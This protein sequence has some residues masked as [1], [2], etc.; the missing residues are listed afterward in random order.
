M[1]KKRE[2]LKN[3]IRRTVLDHFYLNLSIITNSFPELSYI[4][5][6]EDSTGLEVGV[7][8]AFNEFN[9]LRYYMEETKKV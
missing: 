6:S 2:I 3:M 1:T 9:I 4:K 8:T 7:L 5:L